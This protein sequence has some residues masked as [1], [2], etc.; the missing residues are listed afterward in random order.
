[1]GQNPLADEGARSRRS[2]DPRATKEPVVKKEIT[3]APEPRTAEPARPET[4]EPPRILTKRSV[5]RTTLFQTNVDP[6]G[7][8]LGGH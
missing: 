4:Y 5:E 3:P 1:M 7:P 6:G 8:P 2:L